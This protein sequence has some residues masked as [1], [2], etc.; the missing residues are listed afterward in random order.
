MKAL[1]EHLRNLASAKFYNDYDLA[2]AYRVGLRS[3]AD[4]IGELQGDIAR[5]D[6]RIRELEQLFEPFLKHFLKEAK[7][8][9][10]F[11]LHEC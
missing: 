11:G 2:T 1:A 6:Q 10:G 5:R 8:A 9:T 4:T 7:P 3:A